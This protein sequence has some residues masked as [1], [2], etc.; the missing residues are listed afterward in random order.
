MCNHP[1]IEMHFDER[2]KVKHF[3][4]KDCEHSMMFDPITAKF[5]ECY[6]C[7]YCDEYFA[8]EPIP[9]PDPA[10]AAKRKATFCSDDCAYDALDDLRLAYMEDSREFEMWGT[11]YDSWYR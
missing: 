2:N 3:Y 10:I 5:I 4:C 7:E 1:T 9:Y 11:D 8:H 6:Q